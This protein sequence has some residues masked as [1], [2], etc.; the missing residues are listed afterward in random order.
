M[1]APVR[2]R[3]KYDKATGNLLWQRFVDG[4]WTN[5][6]TLS[7][8]QTI[9]ELPSVAP[10]VIEA[11]VEAYLLENPPSGGGDPWTYLKLAENND[12]NATTLANVAGMAFEA[13]A[14]TTYLIQLFGA[15]QTAA[16][17]TGIGFALDIP[18]GSVIGSIRVHSANATIQGTM[19][20]ADRAC[21]AP[22]TAVPTANT[23]MPLT[24]FYVVA[25]GG[26]GGVVQL[27]QRSEVAGSNTRLMA[28]I[29]VM[30]YRAVV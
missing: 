18:S 21:V 9:P 20:R 14:N 25:I 13:L 5:H 30:R 1:T 3:W 27:T 24:G 19:C 6:F 22:S 15:F 28:G 12:V 26:T 8:E 17:T 23:N 2:S 4:A 11:A 10:A 29:T 7:N 16:T